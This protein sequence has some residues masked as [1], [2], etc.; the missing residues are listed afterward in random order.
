[1][2]QTLVILKPDA[3][4]RQITGE[5]ISRFEKVGLRIVGCKMLAGPRPLLSPL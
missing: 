2:E 5:I 1:M 3:I 4:Q